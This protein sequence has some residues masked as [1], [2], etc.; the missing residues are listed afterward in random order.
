[1]GG[2]GAGG[3][4]GE[5][6]ES[7]TVMVSSSSPHAGVHQPVLQRTQLHAQ[8]GGPVCPR[9]LLPELQGKPPTMPTHPPTH[10]LGREIQPPPFP[11]DW[12]CMSIRSTSPTGTK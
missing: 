8:G 10:G 5:G 11:W 1:M 7:L 6:M 3:S 12:C 9:R 4:N 2:E